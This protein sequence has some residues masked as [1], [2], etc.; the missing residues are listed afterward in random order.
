MFY[1]ESITI[2][3]RNR[4]QKLKDGF[5]NWCEVIGYTRAAAHLSS[6][7]LHDEAKRCMMELK[8]LK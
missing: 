4:F 8:K 1:V 3:N 7:G 2:D 6:M 5:M